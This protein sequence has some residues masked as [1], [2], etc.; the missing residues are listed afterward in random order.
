MWRHGRPRPCRVSTWKQGRSRPHRL[1]V[2]PSQTKPTISKH[3]CDMRRIYAYR[4]K[5]PHLQW[6][7]KTYFV[8]FNTKN[9][10]ILTPHSRTLVLETCI[11]GNGKKFE[12]HAAVVMP[13]HVHLLLTPLYDDQGEVSLPEILQ[14]IKSVSAHKVNKYLGRR[15]RLWQ[16]ESFESGYAGGGERARKD[17][18]HH[19]KSGP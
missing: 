16:E 14:E 1:N 5:L 19:G 4:R 12:L 11:A 10:E 3:H 2:Q 15:G 6:T 7:G 9:R 18:L 8:T 17:R 13:D